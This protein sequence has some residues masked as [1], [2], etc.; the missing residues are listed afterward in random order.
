MKGMKVKANRKEYSDL[1]GNK[2]LGPALCPRNK[3]TLLVDA[4]LLD[5]YGSK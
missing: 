1:C 5:T 2:G 4:Y 3:D